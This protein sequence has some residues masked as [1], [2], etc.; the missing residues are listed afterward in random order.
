MVSFPAEVQPKDPQIRILSTNY[1]STTPIYH[2][3]TDLQLF[4][5]FTLTLTS[6][7]VTRY[8]LPFAQSL[9]CCLTLAVTDQKSPTLHSF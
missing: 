9:N 3:I 5:Q 4:T 7:L 8:N 1:Y 2:F 6:G